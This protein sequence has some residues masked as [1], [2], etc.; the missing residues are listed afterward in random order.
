MCA[1][2]VQIH[3]SPTPMAAHA[4]AQMDLSRVETTA[5]V[6]MANTKMR[7]TIRAKTA[8]LITVLNAPLKLSALS[9]QNHLS[10]MINLS[11]CALSPISYRMIPAY[12][13][14]DKLIS[15]EPAMTAMLAGAWNALMIT[16]A[17]N[18]TRPSW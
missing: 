13:M 12:V 11:A 7:R 1:L 9:A 14:K 3:S 5:Y 6:L 2:N 15:K 4:S 10:S 16:S 17:T 8:L 18:A